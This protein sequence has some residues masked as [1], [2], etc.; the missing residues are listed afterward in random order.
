M[1]ANAGLE[2]IVEAS[3][4]GNHAMLPHT[5]LSGVHDTFPAS[6]KPR[7]Y[8]KPLETR[9]YWTGSFPEKILRGT[10]ETRHRGKIKENLIK[11][12]NSKSS[13]YL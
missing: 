10:A 13:F 7:G 6:R 9:T 8:R 3:I 5:T 11:I 12:K 2:S 1:E 4:T